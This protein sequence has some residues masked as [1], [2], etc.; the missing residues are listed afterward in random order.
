[1]VTK[2]QARNTSIYSA[3]LVAVVTYAIFMLRPDCA[4]WTNAAI[5]GAIVGVI[6]YWG[7]IK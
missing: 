4:L 3:F 1:M 6:A 2:K 5:S 7:M